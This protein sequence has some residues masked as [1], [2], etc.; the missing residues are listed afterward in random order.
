MGFVKPPAAV[1]TAMVFIVECPE[2]NLGPGY[3]EAADGGQA[4]R[5]GAR[6][7]GSPG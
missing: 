2:T 3:R 1:P 5:A 6:T 4:A 7:G